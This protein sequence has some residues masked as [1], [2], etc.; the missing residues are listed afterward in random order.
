M[1]RTEGGGGRKV[2]VG[3]DTSGSEGHG[4]GMVV[5][6][7]PRRL[8]CSVPERSQCRKSGRRTLRK[9]RRKGTGHGGPAEF[10]MEKSL[11]KGLILGGENKR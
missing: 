5:L 3:F 11:R 10:T 6:G 1:T 4:V 9:E 2:G 8:C 7:S